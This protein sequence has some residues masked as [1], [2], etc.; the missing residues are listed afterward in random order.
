MF[1][2]FHRF[3]NEFNFSPLPNSLTRKANNYVP[4]LSAKGYSCYEKERGTETEYEAPSL[5]ALIWDSKFC[6]IQRTTDSYPKTYVLVDIYT[7]DI[8]FLYKEFKQ[9]N[10][11]KKNLCALSFMAKGIGG[12]N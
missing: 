6:Y 3:D 1:P 12:K 8:C 7:E 2:S 4:P 11:D 5:P 9:L 10:Y